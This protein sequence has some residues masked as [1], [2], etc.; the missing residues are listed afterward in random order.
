MTFTLT[1]SASALVIADRPSW[2]AGILTSRF[3]RSTAFQMSRASARVASVSCAS[4]GL[5][6][7]DTRPSTPPLLSHVLRNTSQASRTSVTVT[8]R[9]VSSTD[10][11]RCLSSR[12][13][14]S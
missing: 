11:P 4:S 5:T 14:A 10:A 6:S 2:V 1:P 8:S 7:S 12:T 3:G 9:T 13:W